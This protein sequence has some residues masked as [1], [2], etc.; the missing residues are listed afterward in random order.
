MFDLVVA[1][2]RYTLS[3]FQSDLTYISLLTPAIKENFGFWGSLGDF[4]RGLDEMTNGAISLSPLVSQPTD[5]CAHTDKYVFLF[6]LQ[7]L[8]PVILQTCPRSQTVARQQSDFCLHK[9]KARGGGS[10]G[11]KCKAL[12][13]LVM[14]NLVGKTR[15]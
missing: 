7:M 12:I 4:H 6:L 1:H 3:S 10:R 14:L 2:M 9:V 15:R 13:L 11:V 8:R 5:V